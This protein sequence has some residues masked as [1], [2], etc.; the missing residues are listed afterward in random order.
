MMVVYTVKD[1]RS[2]AINHSTKKLL[3]KAN[4]YYKALNINY[5]VTMIKQL[6]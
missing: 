1:L 6:N 3:Y 2:A 4:D 5:L